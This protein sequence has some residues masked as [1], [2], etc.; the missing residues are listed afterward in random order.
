MMLLVIQEDLV[1]EVNRADQVIITFLNTHLTV[2]MFL[3]FIILGTPGPRG[4]DGEA[5][6][7]PDCNYAAAAY[8]YQ[9]Q[10][11]GPSYDKG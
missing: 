8:A 4:N 9:P 7:C 5:G 1:I 11:K 2:L 10:Y 3:C 6:R